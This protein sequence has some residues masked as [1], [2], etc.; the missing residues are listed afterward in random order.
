MDG[1]IN[2]SVERRNFRRRTQQHGET[3]DNY[4][5]SLRNLAKTCRFCSDDCLQKNIRDQIIKGLLDG[6]TIEGLF[7]ESGLTLATTI[8][9]CRSKEAAKKNQLQIVARDQESEVIAAFQNPHT[10]GQQR[11]PQ[12]CQGC[13]GT[14]H[15]GG[16]IHCPAYNKACSAC[17]K[18]GHFARVCRSKQKPHQQT[19]GDDILHPSTNAIRL[20]PLQGDHIQLYNIAGDKGEPAPTITVEMATCSVTVL[21]D[22][23]A[24]ISAAGQAIVGILGHRLDNLTP[25]EISPR[26]VNGACM[27]PLGKIPVTIHLQRKIY[28]DDIHIFPGVSGA[29]IS[30]KAAKELG[31]LPPWYPHPEKSPQIMQSLKVNTNDAKDYGSSTVEQLTQE[32]PSIFSVQVSAMKGEL[33][34]ISLMKNAE[35]FCFKAP[36]SI[37][38][39]YREKLRQEIDSLLEQD[40]ITEATEWCAPIVVTPKKGM[41]DIRLCVDLSRLNRYVHREQHQSPTPAEAVADIAANEAQIFTVLD[42]K[43]GYHQC[44]MERAKPSQLLTTFITPFGHF[45]YR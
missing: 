13:G 36:C 10:P 24:N 34:T 35:P 25:S 42:A 41:D 37:P 4:L 20:Q 19:P 9:K 23:G 12:I 45:K 40:I 8:T 32:F 1:H 30:W 31:I 26:A 14:Q 38:F 44:L 28:K 21:P 33:F 29:L 5:I 3:C 11:R 18:M 7:Q 22:S 2:E 6:N 17:H 16:R 15:K 39:A 43:K 27:K